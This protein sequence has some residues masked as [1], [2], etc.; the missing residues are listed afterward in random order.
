[1]N[2]NIKLEA[3]QNQ[4]QY[5]Q[6]GDIAFHIQLLLQLGQ[7]KNFAA[8]LGYPEATSNDSAIKQWVQAQIDDYEGLER[9]EMIQLMA[10]E[11]KTKIVHYYEGVDLQPH[12]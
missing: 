3:S 5:A 6:V 11:I 10:N 2:M 1:M 12:F 7:G 8:A 9:M 4:G